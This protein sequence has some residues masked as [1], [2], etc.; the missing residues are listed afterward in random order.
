[1]KNIEYIFKRAVCIVLLMLVGWIF[2]F[3]DPPDMASEAY[4]D[5]NI[6]LY[7]VVDDISGVGDKEKII[8]KDVVDSDNNRF[9]NKIIIYSDKLPE[10]LGIGNVIKFVG[11]T[12][13]FEVP[14]NPGQFNELKYYSSLGIQARMF[15]TVISVVDNDTDIFA[16]TIRNIRNRYVE[17][18]Y[19][20]L[21]EE[22]AGTVAAIV[23]GEK[24]GLD[25]S[26]KELYRENGFAHVLA[27]S[28]LHISL[29]GAGLFYILRRYFMPMRLAAVVS[30]IVLFLYGVMIGFPVSTRRAIVMMIIM[31]GARI[32][33]ERYDRLN[34]LALAAIV[35]LLIHPQALYE[36]G[37]LLS[38]GTVLG[39]AL[40]MGNFERLV[41]SEKGSFKNAIWDIVS[42]S[43]GISLI[44]LPI[45]IN[46]YHEV[47]VFSVVVNIV[48]LP[49]LS[50]LLGGAILAGC[51]GIVSVSIS[52]FFFGIVYYILF[53]YQSFCE[54]MR[55]PGISRIIIG[56]RSTF[57]I[58]IY[59]LGM[60]LFAVFYDNKNRKS[61]VNVSECFKISNKK[62]LNLIEKIIVNKR[63]TAVAILFASVCVFVAPIASAK[64]D[65]ERTISDSK[66]IITN[67][68]VGQGD[69]AVVR[70]GDKVLMI[71]GGS[72][73]VKEVGK[74]RIVPFLKYKGISRIDYIFISHSDEDHISGILEIL[75]KDDH[76]G[77]DVGCVVLPRI[78][79]KDDN[80]V[81]L[82]EEV[83]DTGLRLSYIGRGDTI[84]VPVGKG[85]TCDIRCLHPYPDYA[86]VD[87]NDYSEVL[88]LDYMDF[89]GI[90]MGDLG[91][92]GEEIIESGLRDV[93]YLKVGHH[94]SKYSSSDGFLE[95]IRPE[96]A[97]ASAGKNNRYGHP[98]PETIER[99]E[100]MGAKVYSTINSGA[101]TVVSDGKRVIV[102]KYL[103]TNQ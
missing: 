50:L 81:V 14:S 36:S 84:S 3:Y 31:L 60:I 75:E 10:D 43:L 44:T 95:R 67:L 68:D 17:L 69:C 46:S 92:H 16:E 22:Q 32:I 83:K 54:L 34:S 93:D 9:C 25:T 91:E 66:V 63:K 89:E 39:I 80:Y 37:F 71:D 48:L 90:F 23:V 52:S 97:V 82:E 56:H 79:M 70:I 49:F 11:A 100:S 12:E 38:Y 27:I 94:G 40:F 61:L 99:L 88:E 59:Y 21:P 65:A 72:T 2:F 47:P 87:A 73:S 103:E 86:W 5:K 76:F 58:L 62:S 30:G 53:F 20:A 29:I 18:L 98:T 57:S 77:I 33:G 41:I 4:E 51:L 13:G 24:S 1:M 7:G 85:A 35:E 78:N 15:A 55:L 74:Y 26:V 64:T 28:G 101:V 102:E 96:I 8:A 6:T 45:I 42:G 19:L